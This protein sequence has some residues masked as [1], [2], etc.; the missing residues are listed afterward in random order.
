MVPGKKGKTMDLN[1]D[2]IRKLQGLILFTVIVV[3][4]GVNYRR[5]LDLF[6]RMVHI[7]WPFILGSVIAFVLN[8]PMRRIE[9]LLPEAKKHPKLKRPVSLC[10][11]IL[12]VA[13]ILFL[14]SFV[15]VPE[16]FQTF[17]TLRSSVPAFFAS[18]Q[19]GA[20]QLFASYPELLDYVS[21][22]S[23]NWDQVL[24][25]VAA[26]LKNGAGTMLNTTFSAAVSIA[27]GVTNFSIAFIFSIYI[28]LQKETLKRQFTLLLTAFLPGE[29]VK[30]ILYVAKLSERTFSSFLTGQCLE[31]V[32][33]GFM[34]FVTLTVLKLPYAILIGVLIAFTALIPMF[35]AFIGLGVGTFLM[36][37]ASPTSALIFVITFFVLQQIEGNLIYPHVVG[38][39]VGLPSIWVLAAVTIGGSMMG[40]AGMLLFIPLCSVFYTL[41]REAA[42]RRLKEKG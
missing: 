26:F 9:A 21:S 10:L 3:V 24:T 19:T 33:L 13:G 20:E 38:N 30:E 15:V 39:S 22:I 14:V 35:G 34:F 23:I 40:I 6:G 42:Y 5:I 32:I 18:L 36:L 17:W 37:M 4:A 29:L 8:V 31:A 16:L 2:T 12:L 28:L 25:D 1:R 7:I 11:S 27:T 41:L